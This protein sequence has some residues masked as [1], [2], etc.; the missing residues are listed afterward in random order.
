MAGLKNMLQTSLQAY[1]YI[2][3]DDAKKYRPAWF[4]TGR[5]YSPWWDKGLHKDTVRRWGS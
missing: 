2:Y 4:V 5:G 3:I 1:I